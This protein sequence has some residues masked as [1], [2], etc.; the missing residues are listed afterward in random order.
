[1][2]WAFEMNRQQNEE[3]DLVIPT[4]INTDSRNL[5][6]ASSP[7][8]LQNFVKTGMERL[9]GKVFDYAVEKHIDI[10]SDQTDGKSIKPSALADIAKLIS[11]KSDALNIKFA[12]LPLCSRV[13]DDH[14]LLA[15]RYLDANER[16]KA[17]EQ[18]NLHKK[19]KGAYDDLNDSRERFLKLRKPEAGV[20]KLERHPRRRHRR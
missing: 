7:K 3:A 15:E 11:N 20:N 6:R 17:E 13:L 8:E 18:I 1:M 5:R 2:L 4:M 10:R 9:L 19:L 16:N 12:S 14:A